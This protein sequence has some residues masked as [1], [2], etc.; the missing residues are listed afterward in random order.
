[1]KFQRSS[2][3]LIVLQLNLDKQKEHL[4][5]CFGNWQE[6]IWFDYGRWQLGIKDIMNLYLKIEDSQSNLLMCL[7]WILAKN[8]NIFYV[9]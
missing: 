7:S 6:N 8:S 1:M 5:L 9:K 3:C 2:Q 4:M